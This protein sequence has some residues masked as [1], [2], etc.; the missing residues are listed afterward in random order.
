MV[1]FQHN[2]TQACRHN[3]HDT[4]CVLLE[5]EYWIKLLLR[6]SAAPYFCITCKSSTKGKGTCHARAT[7][8]RLNK[9]AFQEGLQWMAANSPPVSARRLLSA[10]FDI[11]STT[12][13]KEGEEEEKEKERKGVRT[14]RETLSQFPF[15]GEITY[16]N[17][18]F[19]SKS[20]SQGNKGMM[21]M[22]QM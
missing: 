6:T 8:P 16:N 21:Q 1:L 4:S 22:N 3:G 11:M 7:H 9:R 20:S 10:C 13:G 12:A 18:T 15:E 14:E 5:S 2:P 19:T 17:F